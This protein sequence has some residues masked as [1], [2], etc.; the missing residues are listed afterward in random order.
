MI[1]I[2]EQNTSNAFDFDE[3]P[4]TIITIKSTAP[5]A[6]KTSATNANPFET[7]D[8]ER[9]YTT[10]EVATILDCESGQVSYRIRCGR[11]KAQKQWTTGGRPKTFPAWLI[12]ESAIR[13][14]MS[15]HVS[16]VIHKNV[17]FSRV[18]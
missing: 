5:I 15:L 12:S 8:T 4:E 7:P 10:N 14:Y 18:K 17:D 13:A 9:W 6:V 1:T 11:I 3:M 16:K 2:E